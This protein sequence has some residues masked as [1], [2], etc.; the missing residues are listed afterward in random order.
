MRVR[1]S[2]VSESS[3]LLAILVATMAGVW[4]GRETGEES[5]DDCDW[6]G[7]LDDVPLLLRRLVVSP[8]SFRHG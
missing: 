4:E 6:E 7:G 1:K 8:T 2:S 3:L 5:A